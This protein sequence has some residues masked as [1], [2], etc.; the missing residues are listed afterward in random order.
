MCMVKQITLEGARRDEEV[1][2]KGNKY[3]IYSTN[4]FDL[5]FILFSIS[6]SNEFYPDTNNL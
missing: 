3:E 4:T 2:I 1:F 6:T 5:F